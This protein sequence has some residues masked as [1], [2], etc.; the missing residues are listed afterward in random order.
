LTAGVLNPRAA[1]TVTV[2]LNSEATNFL[3]GNYSA[4]VSFHDVTGGTAQNRQF[5]FYVGNGG[6]ESGDFT[7][8]SLIGDTNA[9]FVLAAD[10]ADVAGTNAL[11][12]VADA[13]FVHSGLYGAYLGESPDTGS[14]SQAV[15]TQPGR[16]YLVSFWLTSIACEGE[17]IPNEFAAKWN[18]STLC[19]RTNLD[20]FGWTK[21]QF[22]VP[23][24]AAGTTLEFDFMNSPAG[25][26]LD[27]IS[28]Q[29]APA[30]V[31]Q[32]VTLT[33]GLLTLT[34]SGV[35]GLS[36]QLQSAA[37]LSNPNWTNVVP[38][39]T[40]SGDL[41][42]ASEPISQA[43]SQQFYRVVLLPSP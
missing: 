36:Y 37:N 2:S 17:T 41:V 15:A 5:D 21:L 3:I 39:I 32:S 8:W 29:P 42:S 13:Q 20:A 40:A 6:F 25:F 31:L 34:W 30:P 43:S 24:S 9:D 16:Q 4:N 38:A 35:A 1:S 27:D 33:G 28:V 10:D 12:G 18:G 19:A 26:G 22:V 14:L 11:P 23:A 7:Y